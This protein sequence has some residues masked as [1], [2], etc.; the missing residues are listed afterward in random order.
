MHCDT[1]FGWWGGVIPI[2]GKKFWRA[3]P[4]CVLL[5]KN[6]WNSVP[7][8]SVTKITTNGELGGIRKEP[9]M[10]CIQL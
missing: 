4:V 3:V 2:P 6:F 7:A 8:R 1:K 10:A 5:R 9:V